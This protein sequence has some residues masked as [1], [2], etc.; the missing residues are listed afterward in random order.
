MGHAA[1][2]AGSEEPSPPD[3]AQRE[4]AAYD[5]GFCQ[6][7]KA[8]REVAGK[9]VESLMRRFGETIGEL[10]RLKPLLYEQAER[11][12]V[13]LALQVARKIVHREV[14]VDQEII[15]TLVRVA[16]SHV[17]V[18]SAVT[19]RLHPADYTFMLE[20]RKA[21]VKPGE[22]DRD[23]VL[24]ADKSIERGGCLVETECGDIDARVEAEFL[25]VERAFFQNGNGS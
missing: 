9:Q 16:L 3:A 6:G 10:G 12:V 23:I 18:K 22:A 21:S 4:K 5:N 14:M 1:G 7:E 20:H 19:V 13:R 15:Q 24:V 2:P 8:G 25:E 11:E 17:A